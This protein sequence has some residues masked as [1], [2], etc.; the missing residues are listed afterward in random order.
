MGR[1]LIKFGKSHDYPDTP[2]PIRNVVPD[3]YKKSPRFIDG[4]EASYIN[5]EK[6][7]R[8]NIGMK[9]CVPFFDSMI[10]GYTAT[11]WQDVL[12]T[13]RP[14]GLKTE[15]I[16]EPIPMIERSVHG[17]ELLPIPAGH[18][19]TQ[20]AWVTPF[21]IQTPPGYS[22]LITHP[23]NRFDLPFTTLTGIHDSD[24]IMPHGH[25]PFYIKDNFEG[26]IPAGTPIYQIFPFKRDNWDSE[27]DPSLADKADKR[28]WQGMTKLFGHYKQNVWKKKEY[29]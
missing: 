14:D 19:H 17:M 20:Y 24:A 3:W 7:L 15:W 27:F 16:V 28:M 8:P 5:T 11:L 26:V 9:M 29:N 4:K 2:I 13:R 10:S 1:K 23:F 12:V 6:G 25:L 18:H 21:S 22:V